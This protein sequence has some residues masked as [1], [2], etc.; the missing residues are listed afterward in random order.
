MQQFTKAT[1]ALVADSHFMREFAILF[2]SMSM[3]TDHFNK[4]KEH[5]NLD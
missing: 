1:F 3:E 5:S 4:D 2:Q